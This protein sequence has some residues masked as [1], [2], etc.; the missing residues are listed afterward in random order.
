MKG[1]PIRSENTTQAQVVV[2]NQRVDIIAQKAQDVN[3]TE[4]Q[5]LSFTHDLE[6]KLRSGFYRVAVYT[7]IGLLGA[8][9]F[10][11]Q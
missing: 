9:N 3:I 4:S 1:T 11:L 8:A 6:E 10:R 5:R 7:D 2:N